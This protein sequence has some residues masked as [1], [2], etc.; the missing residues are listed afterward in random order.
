MIQIDDIYGSYAIDSDDIS[1]LS[2]HENTLGVRAGTRLWKLA[3][4][5]TEEARRVITS[6]VESLPYHPL[7]VTASMWVHYIDPEQITVVGP[8]LPCP[9]KGSLYHL[10]VDTVS[11]ELTIKDSQS[12]LMGHRSM[13][14][15]RILA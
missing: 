15:S 2:W 4:N 6:V 12:K 10:V 1:Y 11:G 9:K 3:F 8:V 7:V 13:I 5:T 14:L